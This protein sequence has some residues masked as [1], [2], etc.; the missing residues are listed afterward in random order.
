M[1]KRHCQSWHTFSSIRWFAVF[2]RSFIQIQDSSIRTSIF[3]DQK[4]SF[5]SHVE[6]EF[7]VSAYVFML[8]WFAVCER[9]F[10]RAADP[11]SVPI[12]GNSVE[13]TT[14][15]E[16]WLVTFFVSTLAGEEHALPQVLNPP[17]CVS[18]VLSFRSRV[19]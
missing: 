18:Y 1:S 12:V 16:L 10:T 4:H 6:E 11:T 17:L 7:S 9:S 5:L 2:E 15:L 14:D 8:R 19:G 13:K 3:L